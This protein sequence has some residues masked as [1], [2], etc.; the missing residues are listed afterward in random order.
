VETN[1]STTNSSE[2]TLQNGNH[3][4][5]STQQELN[6]LEEQRRGMEDA[7]RQFKELRQ[8]IEKDE[9]ARENRRQEALQR[10]QQREWQRQ[11]YQALSEYQDAR[12]N[13][14]INIWKS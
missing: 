13:S 8:Q 6:A 4:S 14:I 3:F 2:T 1:G 11:Y 12:H 10:Q 5:E 9:K 7:T